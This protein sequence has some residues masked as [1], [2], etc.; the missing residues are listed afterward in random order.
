MLKR[1]AQAAVLMATRPQSSYWCSLEIFDDDYIV[2]CLSAFL[3]YQCCLQQASK[4]VGENEAF[5]AG[6]LL[7]TTF[8]RCYTIV[9]RKTCSKITCTEILQN[10]SV[11]CDTNSRLTSVSCD[12]QVWSRWCRGLGIY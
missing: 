9:W 12:A 11:N 4:G 2:F 6:L 7:K 1:P 8:R 3:R 10:K 5:T